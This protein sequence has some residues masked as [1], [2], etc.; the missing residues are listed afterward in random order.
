M[1]SRGLEFIQDLLGLVGRR[2]ALATS[3][4][5]APS[6]PVGTPLTV[7]LVGPIVTLIGVC[8]PVHPEAAELPMM[9]AAEFDGLAAT[10]KESRRGPPVWAWFPRYAW[11]TV[12][13]VM[14]AGSLAFL[15]TALVAFTPRN[16]VDRDKLPV[17]F[18]Y[19]YF[20]RR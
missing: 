16:G 18:L 4:P 2:I 20:S 17:A 19:E 3:R 10:I 5:T 12:C 9:D 6:L 15:L 1:G 8:S 11:L 14:F 7:M 13:L